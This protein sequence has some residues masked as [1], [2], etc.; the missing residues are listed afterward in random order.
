MSECQCC[1]GG[2]KDKPTSDQRVSQAPEEN[3]PFDGSAPPVH[4]SPGE[5]EPQGASERDASERVVNV[6]RQESSEP[7]H[8][9]M[10]TETSKLLEEEKPGQSSEATPEIPDAGPGCGD[11]LSLGLWLGADFLWLQLHSYA[12][13]LGGGAVFILLMTSSIF[14]SNARS[15]LHALA[16]AVWIS[17]KVMWMFK[18]MTEDPSRTNIRLGDSYL[19][20]TLGGF[21]RY[22]IGL[23]VVALLIE[24]SFMLMPSDWF[25]QSHDSW[26]GTR[27]GFWCLKDLAW[28]VAADLSGA[29]YLEGT[30]RHAL[31][32]IAAIVWIFASV[33]VL[34]MQISYSASAFSTIGKP[35]IRVIAF[36]LMFWAVG[37]VA[38]SAGDVLMSDNVIKYHDMFSWPDNWLNMRW[39]ASWC[40][41][42]F[43]VVPVG[44][45]V[46][47]APCR[48]E[49][50]I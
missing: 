42:V 44:L 22:I 3:L 8:T 40:L 2:K 50:I 9:A 17:G 24:V 26:E 6:A 36:A 11:L 33:V 7:G 38:W 4:Q 41:L 10:P 28:Y 19:P 18:D 35:R 25:A 15:R 34:L 23:F 16:L 30:S 5:S 1:L 45:Q 31:W 47:L 27:I 12:P 13:I 37:M 46:L 49:S 32:D 14:G 20:N 48:G 29:W 43:A 21:D 39:Y